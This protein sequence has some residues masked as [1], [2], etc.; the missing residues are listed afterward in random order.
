[1]NELKGIDKF[2][3]LSLDSQLLLVVDNLPVSNANQS[4]LRPFCEPIDSATVDETGKHPESSSENLS[5]WGHCQYDVNVL[6]NP[7]QVLR[8]DI[9]FVWLDAFFDAVALAGVDN[10]LHFLLLI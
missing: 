2:I 6:F 3:S 10:F 9:H 5:Q 7:T 4:F 1:M 8:K